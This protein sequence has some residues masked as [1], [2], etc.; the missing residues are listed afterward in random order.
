MRQG[1]T[2]DC[3]WKS[4]VMITRWQKKVM[5]NDEDDEDVAVAVVVFVVFV[6]LVAMVARGWWLMDRR[7][8]HPPPQ[9]DRLSEVRFNLESLP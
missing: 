3:Q 8:P 6:G 9:K 2:I 7:T 4:K 1:E 5:I